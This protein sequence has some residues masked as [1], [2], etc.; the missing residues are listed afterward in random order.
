MA[1]LSWTWRLSDWSI[2]F[3]MRLRMEVSRSRS[4]WWAGVDTSY[5]FLGHRWCDWS[6]TIYWS[7]IC[8]RV[9]HKPTSYPIGIQG[10]CWLVH[11]RLPKIQSSGLWVSSCCSLRLAL[12]SPAMIWELGH[13]FLHTTDRTLLVKL[14]AQGLSLSY[15]MTRR[16]N[17]IFWHMDQVL[18]DRCHWWFLARPS[19]RCSCNLTPRVVSFQRAQ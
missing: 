17:G 13:L 11:S 12:T 18:F 19:R 6:R 7:R 4:H 16:G 3:L 9:R 2:F 15:Y 14:R 1:A 8:Q 10:Y 5:Y